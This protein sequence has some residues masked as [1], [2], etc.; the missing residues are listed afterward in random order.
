MPTRSSSTD[1]PNKG[2]DGQAQSP[3]LRSNRSPRATSENSLGLGRLAA[4]A[5]RQA[6]FIDSVHAAYAARSDSA[7]TPSN[8][9][10]RPDTSSEGTNSRDARQNA[11]GD[12]ASRDELESLLSRTPTR[13]FARVW[14]LY[15]QAGSPLELAPQVLAHQ[16][17][18]KDAS[19][20]LQCDFLFDS[21]P[22]PT[23][24]DYLNISRALLNDAKSV[25][26]GSKRLVAV[27]RQACRA[28]RSSKC[29]H[30]SFF[31]S[32]VQK[33][34]KTAAKLY[35]Y[36]PPRIG[37]KA[38]LDLAWDLHPEIM[39]QLPQRIADIIGL[40]KNGQLKLVNRLEPLT[41]FLVFSVVCD[42]RTMAAAP[43]TL[44]RS[45]FDGLWDLEILDVRHYYWAFVTL[46]RI[47]RAKGSV[48]SMLLYRSYRD[49]FPGVAVP[50]VTM[51]GFFVTLSQLGIT[52][53]VYTLLED[54]RR[55]YGKPP[56]YAYL[57][58]LRIYSRQ[59]LVDD[60]E[61]LLDMCIRDHG[62][63]RDLALLTPLINAHSILG[64][65]D[66]VTRQMKK[67]EK[68]YRLTP[69]IAVWNTLLKAHC[70][71]GDTLGAF[72]V[73]E[74]MQAARV[75][76]DAQSYTTL[77]NMLARR[78]DIGTLLDVFAHFKSLDVAIDRPLIKPV[79]VALCEDDRLTA[80][81]ALAERITKLELAGSPTPLWNALL[82]KYASLPDAQGLSRVHGKMVALGVAPDE[83]TY[84][85]LILALTLTGRTSSAV[86][87]LERLH[88]SRQLHARPYH[89]ALLLAGYTREGN[90]DMVH[91]IYNEIKARFGKASLS[92]NL[93]ALKSSIARD[94]QAHFEKEDCEGEAELILHNAEPLLNEILGESGGD[95]VVFDG[96]QPGLP[97]RSASEAFPDV[98]YE[99]VMQAYAQHGSVERVSALFHELTK[100]R[101]HFRPA[102]VHVAPH[103]FRVLMLA[104]LRA[105]DHDAVESCWKSIFSGMKTLA[106]PVS[107]P[108]PVSSGTAA[109]PIIR[110]FKYSL[111]YCVSLFMRSLASQG[112]YE[113]IK[114]LISEVE[115]AGFGLTTDNYSLYV[116][117]LAL[118]ERPE[119]QLAA[120]RHFERLFIR[121][122]PGWKNIVRGYAKRPPGAPASI[123][124][125]ED[126]THDVRGKP[127]DVLGKKGRRLWA[128]LRPDWMQP[129]YSTMVH[130]ASAYLAFQARAVMD[131][132]AELSKLGEAAPR[133]LMT[134]GEMP[135]LSERFQ[136]E[137]LKGRAA[138][139]E[140]LAGGR[141]EA[142]ADAS[143][144]VWVGGVLG[145]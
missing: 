80:A 56:Y 35:Q 19:D 62:P 133:T 69:D 44:I 139:R 95:G 7:A 20:I 92:S 57:H 63:P 127:A 3:S 25:A 66:D 12:A 134:L 99:Q 125:V 37:E 48:R 105:G 123:D 83:M 85:A 114:Q 8:G 130:L 101:R 50:S 143:S 13:D 52:Q 31:T 116:R 36:K 113:Q 51:M 10:E 46:Q 70:V 94:L 135:V 107:G 91:V 41:N 65:V 137:L 79:V 90:R 112:K 87:I 110:S 67:L 128:R 4:D 102:D 122:F 71:N 60:C 42:L 68:V 53:G 121:N 26:G 14:K 93:A 43:I 27:C 126:R 74:D 30:S 144:P 106:A 1:A 138:E 111:S 34:W 45:I 61:R 118:S 104:H 29:F 88:R 72:R 17:Y 81:E 22:D 76:P 115:A 77:L 11:Q 16:C 28:K 40:V 59:G 33:D 73:L 21:I 131:G 6:A 18:S 49:R 132:G 32:I 136:K 129:T 38:Q 47:D 23:E 124:L 141:R 54:S 55:F 108:A 142:D 103:A 97:G 2:P 15:E 86:L 96:P 84:G 119:D 9:T 82:R 39:R 120:F 78:G 58:A 117:L 100:A 24:D 89:Y 64:R 75:R 109:P 140:P 98:F 5:Q 145:L